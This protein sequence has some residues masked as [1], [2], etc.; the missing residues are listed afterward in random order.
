[1]IG[2]FNFIIAAV[3]SLGI[4]SCSVKFFLL[5][6][7]LIG[8]F[9]PAF[10]SL[11]IASNASRLT[12]TSLSNEVPVFCKIP[13]TLKGNSSCKDWDPIPWATIILSSNL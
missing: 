12:N 4:K 9:E 2:D 1:M 13:L 10:Q 7:P 6:V 5:F 11:W 3:I 8:I